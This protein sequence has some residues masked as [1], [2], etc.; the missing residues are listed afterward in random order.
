[1]DRF[2]SLYFSVLYQSFLQRFCQCLAHN[3]SED[4]TAE[5]GT[6][7]DTKLDLLEEAGFEDVE[8]V[9]YEGLRHSILQETLADMV[10]SDILE[11]IQEHL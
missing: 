4:V 8:S 10:T 3:G 6:Y 7:G 1:M 11:W 9:V 2:T 5:N